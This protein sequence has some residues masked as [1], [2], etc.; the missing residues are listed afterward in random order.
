MKV[1]WVLADYDYCPMDVPVFANSFQHSSLHVNCWL[2]IKWFLLLIDCIFFIISW[3]M[4]TVYLCESYD[5]I[6]QKNLPFTATTTSPEMH[7]D[8]RDMHRAQTQ[9]WLY[10]KSTFTL[11]M[12]GDMSDCGIADSVWNEQ[13]PWG[14][15]CMGKDV[16][17]HML[18]LQA[19]LFRGFYSVK[20]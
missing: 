4:F 8:K 20:K 12:L 14:A 7:A 17:K 9:A 18:R 3:Q 16:V 5:F 19:S 15:R 13:Y 10:C 11:L 6:L 1:C 2:W